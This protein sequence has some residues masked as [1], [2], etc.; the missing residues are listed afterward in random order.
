MFPRRT[1]LYYRV[2]CIWSS[3]SRMDSHVD[4]SL[5]RPMCHAG[6]SNFVW[7]ENLNRLRE[8]FCELGRLS[9]FLV[10][11]SH[12]VSLYGGLAD[13]VIRRCVLSKMADY[14]AL[15]RPTSYGRAMDAISE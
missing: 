8:G 4:T 1:D 3:P 5:S 12:T 10:S 11:H 6:E 13:G 14:A 9:T 15:S 2:E 7:H